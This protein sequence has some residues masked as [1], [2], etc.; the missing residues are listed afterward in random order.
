MQ[1]N[2]TRDLFDRDEEAAVQVAAV[3]G[4]AVYL[5]RAVA[6]AHVAAR[7]GEPACAGPDAEDVTDPLRPLAL[8]ADQ[9]VLD[10]EDQVVASTFGH[11]T[12]HHDSESRGLKSGCRLGDGSLVAR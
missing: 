2:L 11:R 8:H 7:G 1:V 5:L 12:Q 10:V 3:R 9:T 4:D 6:R